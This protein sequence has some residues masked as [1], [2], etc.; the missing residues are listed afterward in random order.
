MS[1]PGHKPAA[2][3]IASTLTTTT[4]N[5]QD[6]EEIEDD[7]DEYIDGSGEKW[8]SEE[9]F[10]STDDDEFEND[11]DYEENSNYDTDT[12][13]DIDTSNDTDNIDDHEYLE[14]EDNTNYYKNNFTSAR[15]GYFYPEQPYVDLPIIP[16]PEPEASSSKLR[17][18]IMSP[19][20]DIARIYFKFA[21]L[22]ILIYACALWYTVNYGDLSSLDDIDDDDTCPADLSA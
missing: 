2:I 12:D 11:F 7:H 14:D 4:Y 10:S 6:D 13:A 8:S 22:A 16:K 17:Y 1:T 20:C 3:P 5:F 21:I 19:I 18:Y 15:P 9:D